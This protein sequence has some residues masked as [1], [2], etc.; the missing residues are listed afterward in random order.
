MENENIADYM[1]E[2]ET[3]AN[4]FRKTEVSAEEIGELIMK[5]SVHYARYNVRLSD[6]IRAFSFKKAEFQNQTDPT[7]GKAMS[8][9]K[10]EVL[11]DATPE[12][13]V[14]EL[15][16]IHVQNIQEYIN[17]LKSLQRGVQFEYA[18]NT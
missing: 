4:N 17:S 18:S 14:Y 16:R 6:A 10:S 9:S 3:F 13:S 7:S 1:Q 5:M 11:A 12:A 15:A 8:T 2:Y